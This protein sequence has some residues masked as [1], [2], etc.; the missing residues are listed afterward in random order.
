MSR[1]RLTALL[2]ALVTLVAYLPVARNG[3]SCYDDDIYVTDNPIVQNGLTWAGVRWAFKTWHGANWHPV[4][5]LSHE[6][7]CELFG[8][9]AG[10]Q[11]CVNVLFHTA[12]AVL[13]LFLLFRLTGALWPS[14][15][16]AGLFAWHPLH[17]ESVAWISERKDVLS[18]FFEL[19]TLLAYTRHVQKWKRTDGQFSLSELRPPVS[20][21]YWLALGCFAMG[22]MA[23]P[24]LVTLPFVMLLLD[25]WPLRRFINCEAGATLSPPFKL[26]LARFIRLTLEKYPFFLLTTASCVVTFLAQ[27]SNGAVISLAREPF[28]FR[29]ENALV[30]YT[31]YLFKI[32]W[33]SHLAV[34]YPP[35]VLAW[36]TVATAAAVLATTSWLVWRMRRQHPFGLVGWLWFLGTLLPV[37]GFVQVGYAAMA[38]RYTYFPSVGIFFLV[39]F[40][41][42]ELVKRFHVSKSLTAGAAALTLLAC[43]ALMEKQLRYWRNDIV[44]FSHAIAVTKNNDVAYL[45]LGYT[46]EKAGQKKQAMAALREAS[47]LNP[48]RPEPHNDLGN[49]LAATGHT[50]EALTE[51]HKALKINP[52]YVAAHENLGN[53]LLKLG[54]FAAATN[55]FAE[56]A[57]LDPKDWHAPYFMGKALLRQDQDE[58]A[59]SSL[60]QALKIRPNNLQVLTFL[61]QVL[62]SD[63]NPKIRNGR[64]AFLLASRAIALSDRVQPAILDVLAMA[65]AELGRFGDAVKAEQDALDVANAD[66]MTNDIAILQQRLQLYQNHQPFRQSFA[67]L[68]E[69]LK[70]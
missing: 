14:A 58:A 20:G 66:R 2:L 48:Y 7:D 5:W 56:A 1:P 60:H 10:A 9:N 19:L 25:Y 22:L 21:W 59:V 53:A 70:K 36:P 43:L 68:T 57:R 6:L 12:N 37:I 16:V 38:D 50:Q 47:R 63:E 27:Q 65:C 52:G 49:L 51:Y 42:Q 39:A 17:V 34:F 30:T 28:G 24:M 54:Q 64:T 15:F 45:N 13:L 44:L 31:R 35:H 11:H 33:P 46:L 8:L 67:D 4:T 69:P 61:A 32:I 55:Q 3:F 18:T 40:G 41:L 26:H 23:K 29:L 62:A